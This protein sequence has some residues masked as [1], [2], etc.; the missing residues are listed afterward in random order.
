MTFHNIAAEWEENYND[1]YHK[2]V[3]QFS[4][5]NLVCLAS[6]TY[7]LHFLSR[8]FH[9][10]SSLHP[11]HVFCSNYIFLHPNPRKRIYPFVSP[12]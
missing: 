11:P 1:A 4:D 7:H 3:L 8:R 12:F 9:Q 2:N 6:P 5:H 10:A